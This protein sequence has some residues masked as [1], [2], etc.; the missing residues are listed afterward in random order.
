VTPEGPSGAIYPA[1]GGASTYPPVAP[2]IVLFAAPELR[3]RIARRGGLASR[4]TVSVALTPLD[5][6]DLAAL[7][8]ERAVSGAPPFSVNALAAL[9]SASGGIPGRALPLAEAAQAAALARGW[10]QVDER[11]VAA[12]LATD[13]PADESEGAPRAAA[14]QTRLPLGDDST[15]RAPQAQLSAQLSLLGG[16]EGEA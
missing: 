12:T 13:G 14:T 1:D 4:L 3:D 15:P 9:F 10:E 8:H 7:L 6:Q 16:E 5:Q 2:A 11:L